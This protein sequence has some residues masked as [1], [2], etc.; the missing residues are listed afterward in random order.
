MQM[1]IRDSRYAKGGAPIFF[2][3]HRKRELSR[4][5][6]VYMG[7]ERKRGALSDLVELLLSLIHI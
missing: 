4:F 3:L 1:C 5:D 2:F 7:R 6:G